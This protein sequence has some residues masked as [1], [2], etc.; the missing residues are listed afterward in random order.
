MNH[1]QVSLTYSLV[2]AVLCY[3]IAVLLCHLH[4]LSMPDVCLQPLVSPLSLLV[5]L[6][7]VARLP[8][9]FAAKL[10]GFFLGVS[11]TCLAL[12]HLEESNKH[13]INGILV[14]VEVGTQ[15][16]SAYGNLQGYDLL[17]RIL[18]LEDK[19]SCRV[20]LGQLTLKDLT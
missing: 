14:W 7:H 4:P 5:L 11:Y 16:L 1:R 2:G 3:P 12:V 13:S 18:L 15:M 9:L 20:L 19:E 8:P 10:L 6:F 17:G